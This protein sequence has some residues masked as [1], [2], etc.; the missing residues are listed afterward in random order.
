MAF[1]PFFTPSM[2]ALTT[3]PRRAS[4]TTGDPGSMP[5]ANTPAAL[6]KALA[7]VI[8]GPRGRRALAPRQSARSTVSQANKLTLPDWPVAPAAPVD[9]LAVPIAELQA[10]AETGACGSV[11]CWPSAFAAA[12]ICRRK[13]E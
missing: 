7:R 9:A 3:L 12:V 1:H 13:A 4:A 11:T 2:A 8:R 10:C 5:D 6:A